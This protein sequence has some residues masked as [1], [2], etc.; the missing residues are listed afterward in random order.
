MLLRWRIVGISICSV[1]FY[2][3]VFFPVRFRL[4]SRAMF[5][6]CDVSVSTLSGSGRL[7]SRAEFVSSLAD[8]ASLTLGL[9]LLARNRPR[10]L[11]AR[12]AFNPSSLRAVWCDE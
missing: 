1:L 4:F 9:S 3:V 7:C 6:L 8:G 5:I 10:H 2:V 12:C 11:R